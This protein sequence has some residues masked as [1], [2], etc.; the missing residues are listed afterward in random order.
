MGKLFKEITPQLE[1]WIGKQKMFFV[2]TAPLSDEGHVNCSP[3][4]LD[5]FVV[6]DGTTVAYQDLTGSGV[7]TIAHLQENKR[8]TIMF[9]AFDGPPKILRIYGEGEA[10]TP[11]HEDFAQLAKHFPDRLGV[12][13]YIRVRATRIADSCGYAVPL[14]EFKEHRDVLTKYSENKGEDGLKVYREEKNT[15]SIDGLKGLD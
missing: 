4:G 6:L 13:A 1:E 9:C 3:K 2:A 14:Y 12:R 15:L 5:S 8:I 7:E 11:E 10:V